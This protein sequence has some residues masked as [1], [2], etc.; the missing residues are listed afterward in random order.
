MKT[1]SQTDWTIVREIRS[2]FCE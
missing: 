2:F 1:N